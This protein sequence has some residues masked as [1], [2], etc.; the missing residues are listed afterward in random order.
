MTSYLKTTDNINQLLQ[1][2]FLY[3][4]DGQFNKA[5]KIYNKVLHENSKNF[6]ALQLNAT[7]LFQNKKYK[8]ALSIYELALDVNPNF[9]PLYK[10]YAAVLKELKLYDQAIKSYNKAI[11]L[12]PDYTEVY[13]NRGNLFKEL[14][15]FYQAL[16]S[17]DK[18]IKLEPSVAMLYN[19]RG[20]VLKKLNLFIDSLTSYDKAIEL[21]PD[22]AMAYKNRGIVL[23]ELRRFDDALKSYN[24][25]IQLKPDYAS[26][27]NFRGVTLLYLKRFKEALRSYDKAIHL[28]PNYADVILHKAFLKLLLGEYSEGWKLYE[29]RK[30]KE[31]LK[32]NYFLDSKVLKYG[33]SSIKGKSIL[34]YSEQG[35]GDSLQFCRYLSLLK[36]LK[37]KKIILYLDKPLIPLF[38]EFYN[39]IKILEKGKKIPKNIDY[40]CSLL[41]L[42]LLFKTTLNSI[43]KKIPYLSYNH[44]KFLNWKYQL[45]KKNATRI[46]LVWSGSNAH[47]D[48]RNRSLLLNKFSSILQLPFEFHSLQKEIRDCDINTLNNF[49]NLH[50]HQNNLN[51]FSDTAALLN[52]MDLIISVD[53]S[54]V[55]LA[56]AMGKQVWVLLPFI[57]DFRWMLDLKYSPWYP[58]AKLFR[59]T[60]IDDWN[61]VIKKVERE[62]IFLKPNCN[63]K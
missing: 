32:N 7:L 15:F 46:G 5:Q 49:K 8:E 30:K 42:P 28:K 40:Y 25:A 16:N 2:G 23:H 4:Q 55:H 31:T 3:H 21:K 62:L 52:N 44:D 63:L 29:F 51:N 18:A 27:Y 14:N 13:V 17:Y 39:E 19:N 50:Q 11:E 59:Q 33:T 43:P 1:K 58:T 24:Q 9:A 36:K 48:D 6:N 10:N 61:T 56:G 53:T 35:L 60:K 26:A 45:G 20:I 37:P 22:Y 47:K 34:I 12:K 41:S 38:S 57:P 54:V